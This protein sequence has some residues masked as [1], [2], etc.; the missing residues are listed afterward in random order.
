[1]A[2][3]V[4][5]QIHEFYELS[6]RS[7]TCTVRCLAG[8]ARVGAS[9]QLILRDADRPLAERLTISDIQL[10]ANVPVDFLDPG[11]TAIVTATGPIDDAAVRS[12]VA[13]TAPDELFLLGLLLVTR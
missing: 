3:A 2:D 6:S 4:R 11:M 12:G 7:L 10:Y 9:V 13:G 8:P 1:M 5:L